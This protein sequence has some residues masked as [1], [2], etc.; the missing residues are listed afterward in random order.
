MKDFTDG[1]PA[2][3]VIFRLFCL[4]CFDHCK[5]FFSFFSQA[6][7]IQR[8]KAIRATLECSDFFSTHEVIGSSLLF[9]HDRSQASIWL[10]DFAKTVVLPNDIKINHGSVWSVGNHED[11]YLIGI[12]NLIDIFEELQSNV[13]SGVD[14]VPTS[15]IDEK[16]INIVDQINNSEVQV[17]EVQINSGEVQFND[18]EAQLN[19]SEGKNNNTEEQIN[20]SE[21]QINNSEEQIN[22]N[23]EKL[24]NL[25]IES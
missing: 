4:L 22:N 18:F 19:N 10:I 2:C 25:S 24:C 3:I 9:V 21:E 5:H 16:I 23:T 17:N 13:E 12:N 20:N 1:F 11:G 14:S 7:Y 6:K 8:L 15:H